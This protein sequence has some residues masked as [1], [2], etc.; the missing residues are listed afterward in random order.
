MKIT[1]IFVATA[2]MTTTMAQAATGVPTDFT[3]AAESTVNGVVSIKSYASPRTYGS[4]GDFF[5]DPFFEFFF[6]SPRQGQ[7]DRQQQ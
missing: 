4:Q 6:G 2:I 5:N 1:S 3:K 7:R